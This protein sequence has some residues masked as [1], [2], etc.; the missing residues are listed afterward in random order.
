[1]SSERDGNKRRG[2]SDRHSKSKDRIRRSRDR[3]R[4]RSR[5][6]SIRRKRE[7]SPTPLRPLRI[8][9]GRLTRNVTREHVVEIFSVYGEIKNVDFPT[10]RFHPQNGRGFCYVE[11]TNPDDAENAMKHMDGGQI[12]GNE[13]TAAPVLNP[14]PMAMR[15]SPMRRGGPPPM[16][17]RW[18]GNDMRN[19]RNDRRSPDRRDRRSPPRRR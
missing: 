18:R 3:S 5:S 8:H 14:K 1:L 16:R 19:R 10:D 9:I 13:V 2:S 12:D 6:N 7:K 15:R 4:S 17:N 11:F